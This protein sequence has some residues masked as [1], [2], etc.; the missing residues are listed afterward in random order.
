MIN[1][2]LS[3][4]QTVVIET[5]LVTLRNGQPVLNSVP[6]DGGSCEA[7]RQVEDHEHP[8]S[9][10]QR[11]LLLQR[12]SQPRIACMPALQD[13]GRPTLT[14]VP[15]SSRARLLLALEDYGICSC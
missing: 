6:L 10:S 11:A 13:R 8:P 7:I 15:S 3:A 9:S 1:V 12:S 2:S 4:D 14:I 5:S